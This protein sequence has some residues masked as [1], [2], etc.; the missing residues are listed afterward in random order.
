MK[1]IILATALLFG[2][3]LPAAAAVPDDA[4]KVLAAVVQQMEPGDRLAL[5]VEVKASISAG[6]PTPAVTEWLGSALGSPEG[7][8]PLAW[9]KEDTWR[10]VQLVWDIIRQI[11]WS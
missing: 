8:E 3:L 2:A 1:T 4:G 11:I 9:T 5:A 10:L 6:A 7:L